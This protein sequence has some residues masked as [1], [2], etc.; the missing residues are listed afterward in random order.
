MGPHWPPHGA[1]GKKLR[2]KIRKIQENSRKFKNILENPFKIYATETMGGA[3]SEPGPLQDKPDW[4]MFY[5]NLYKKAGPR[6]KKIAL[7]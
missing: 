2:T 7:G 4:G 3:W 6:E 5:A 1:L